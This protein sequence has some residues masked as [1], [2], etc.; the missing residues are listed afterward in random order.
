MTLNAVTIVRNE[1]DS[2]Q[3]GGEDGGG[4][5]VAGSGVVLK[6]R[7]T[8]V[9]L[10]RLGDGTRND[11]SGDPVTSRGHNLLSTKGPAGTCQGFD[12][13]S[14]RI[15]GHPHL[16]DLEHNGGPTKT[17]ALLGGSPAIG[18]ANPATAPARDQRG[19]LRHNPDIGAFERR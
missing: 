11:C 9:G 16:G 13:A 6:V 14:D 5:F 17:V 19:V 4:I 3:A 12:D 1:S 10:N 15:S 18:H 7:N 2:D 8:I